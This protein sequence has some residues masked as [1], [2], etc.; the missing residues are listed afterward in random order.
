MA[1]PSSCLLKYGPSGYDPTPVSKS[2]GLLLCVITALTINTRVLRAG[3]KVQWLTADL[4]S[5]DGTPLAQAH[6]VCIRTVEQPLPVTG[7]PV[8]DPIKPPA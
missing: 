6:A 3:K 4:F 2:P 1:F 5:A 7:D 8:P